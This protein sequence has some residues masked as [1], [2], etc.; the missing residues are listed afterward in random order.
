MVMHTEELRHQVVE[1]GWGHNDRFWYDPGH[2]WQPA[3]E[4]YGEDGTFGKGGNAATAYLGVT[5]GGGGG[6]YGGRRWWPK[7]RL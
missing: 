2:Y 5:S 3:V 6:Y 4:A 1:A 7:T